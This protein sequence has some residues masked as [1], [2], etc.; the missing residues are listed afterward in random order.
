MP[1]LD[2]NRLLWC[3]HITVSIHAQTTRRR[4]SLVVHGP[5]MDA[6]VPADVVAT[7][8]AAS[9]NATAKEPRD[10]HQKSAKYI[11]S[12]PIPED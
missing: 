1:S 2:G 11:L 4:L 8:I 10:H 7:I 5:K 12:A 9:R 6:L 3:A